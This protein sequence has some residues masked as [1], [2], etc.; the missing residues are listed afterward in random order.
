MFQTM[1]KLTP[2]YQLLCIA[3]AVGMSTFCMVKYF[4]NKSVVSV[5]YRQFH[6]TPS[7]VYPSISL[8]FGP[9]FKNTNNT[10]DAKIAE[11][12]KG[13]RKLNQ[14]LLENVTYEDMTLKLDVDKID[15]YIFENELN[16]KSKCTHSGSDCF[17]TIGN[18]G[19]KC[20]T[21]D[22]RFEGQSK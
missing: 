21:H 12:M 18:A 13:Q 11:M 8:C 15:Y 3:G 16:S 6:D 19:T 22:I 4:K 5:N 2:L 1:A 10:E 14:S 20:F 7:D 17:K 9:P